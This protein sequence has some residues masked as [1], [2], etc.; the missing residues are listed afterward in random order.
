MPNRGFLAAACR[1]IHC[2]VLLYES[3]FQA[4]H[5]LVCVPVTKFQRETLFRSNRFAPYVLHG[6]TLFLKCAE[7]A[8]VKQKPSGLENTCK[9][10]FIASQIK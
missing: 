3:L 6:K 5:V 1:T 7:I 10:N 8:L 4:T 9:N 2:F